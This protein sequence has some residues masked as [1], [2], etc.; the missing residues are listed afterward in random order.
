MSAEN[1]LY[2][3]FNLEII[4]S[5]LWARLSATART[6]YPVLLSFSDGNFKPVY[7][8]TKTLLKLTGFK[9]KASLRNARQ[10]LVEKGL[11]TFSRGNGRKNTY[12]QF[13]FNIPLLLPLE[14]STGDLQGEGRLNMPLGGSRAALSGAPKSPSGGMP[15]PASEGDG[16]SSPYNQIHISIDNY[17]PSQKTCLRDNSKGLLLGGTNTEKERWEFL[18]RRFGAEAVRLAASECRLGNVAASLANV[19][20]IL[21]RNRP[22][23]NKKWSEIKRELCKQISPVSLDI[24]CRSYVK[25]EGGLF[26]FK[27]DL[28][29][30]LKT[31]LQG[32]CGEVFFEPMMKD[33]SPSPRLMKS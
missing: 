12:Y 9:H 29:E 6:L 28:P 18:K 19:E 10:E 4:R 7:P 27:D 20:K 11:L 30:H 16:N 25:E 22:K 8:G 5:G 32:V 24:V 2:F 21:Y 26:L 13:C 17:Q 33:P 14:K 3:K 1:L 23:K 15:K 31:A